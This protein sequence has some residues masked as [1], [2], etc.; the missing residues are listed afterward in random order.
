MIGD[1]SPGRARVFLT[2]AS[3]QFLGP[4]QPPIQRVREALS[5]GVKRPGRGADHSP[6]Y[7]AR[8]REY[9]KPYLPS[10][11]TDLWRGDPFKKGTGTTL[12]LP[13]LYYYH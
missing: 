5:L 4:T 1:S 2:T 3:R 13:Y 9:V 6:Q 8:A 10:P 12:H 11:N 7:S